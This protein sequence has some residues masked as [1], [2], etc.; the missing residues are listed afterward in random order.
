MRDDPP[1][2]CGVVGEPGTWY[3]AVAARPSA[4]SEGNIDDR[5]GGRE[6]PATR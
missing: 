5:L 6:L 2:I 3:A 1:R 4:S